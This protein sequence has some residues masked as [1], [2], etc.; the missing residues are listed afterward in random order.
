MQVELPVEAHLEMQAELPVEAHPETPVELAV[1][2]QLG[3][4][5]QGQEQQAA[6]PAG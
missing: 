1:Q 2:V 5:L 4:G 6:R 3:A